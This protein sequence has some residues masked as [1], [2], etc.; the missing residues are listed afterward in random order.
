MSTDF[1]ARFES[2]LGVTAAY[3]GS[4]KIR[5][6]QARAQTHQEK[7]AVEKE[8]ETRFLREMRERAEQRIEELK[9]GSEPLRRWEKLLDNEKNAE[10]VAWGQVDWDAIDAAI[11]LGI[12]TAPQEIKRAALGMF[13]DYIWRVEHKK[14]NRVQ[15]MDFEVTFECDHHDLR[16][17]LDL[18]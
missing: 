3:R 13:I 14:S 1:L 5:N 9:A 2:A 16:L 4:A 17:F 7:Q 6:K 11:H 15:W 12:D 8:K 18:A 10:L